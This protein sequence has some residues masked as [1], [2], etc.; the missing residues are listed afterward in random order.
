MILEQITYSLQNL[1][2][3]KMRSGLTVVSILI[4]VM[5]VFALISFGL[6]IRKYMDVLAQQA[7]TDKLF[8]YAKGTGAPGTNDQFVITQSE[9]DF[10][11]KINGV[12]QIAG[13]YSRPVQITFKKEKKYTYILGFDVSKLDFILEAMSVH[14][15]KGRQLKNDELDKVVLG[16]NYLFEKKIF[17][18]AVNL[19]DKVDINNKS[20]EVVGFFSEVGDPQ[21]DTQVYLTGKAMES[22]FPTVKD[23]Y[24]FV[25]IQAQKGTNTEQLADI[26]DEKLR[27]HKGE[28]KGKE[29]FFVQT[30]AD[31]LQIFNSIVSI[32][33]GVLV[34]IALISLL[35]ASV[36]IMNTMYTAVLERTKEIGVMKAIGARNSNIFFI[37]VF[38]SGFLGAVG[39]MLGV[40]FGYVIASIGGAIAAGAGYSLL[41]PVFPLYLSLSCILFSFSLGA[42]AGLLPAYQA[43]K[44]NPVDSLR[45]E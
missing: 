33:N 41:K 36:N 18:K 23:K 22:L 13:M 16:Y 38:E 21:D 6:G 35:V 19:G 32:L 30:Y 3:R 43:S 9:V 4:G 5:A 10:V 14:I 1:I 45:Y 44:Q 7:G 25:L 2:H 24:G 15:I 40:F 31:A 29:D 34:L 37:F 39:G 42:V 26:I 17:K 28:Q 12:K 20:F 11:S 8:I 27:K